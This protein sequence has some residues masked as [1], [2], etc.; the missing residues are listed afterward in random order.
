VD[1]SETPPPIEPLIF[2]SGIFLS[3]Q[4][5]IRKENAEKEN[6]SRKWVGYF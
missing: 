3:S 1:A 6:E 4:P 5:A 2:L